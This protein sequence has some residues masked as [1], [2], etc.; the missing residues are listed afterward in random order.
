[1]TT[2]FKYIIFLLAHITN[3]FN[4]HV[5]YYEQI[6]TNNTTYFERKRYNKY[7]YKWCQESFTHE[8]RTIV[9]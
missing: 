3:F 8:F 5:S 1:M 6:K 4:I 2:F 7:L 9:T